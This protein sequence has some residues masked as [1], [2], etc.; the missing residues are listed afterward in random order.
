L[1]SVQS[2]FA[3]QAALAA[4]VS[5]WNKRLGPAL[6]RLAGCTLQKIS[7]TDDG[8]LV[9]GVYRPG[10]DR[11][12]VL[13]SIRRGES[14]LSL[15]NVKPPAQNKPGSLVQMARKHL[16]GRSIA[17]AYAS[18]DPVAVVLEFHPPRAQ[19]EQ[20][21]EEEHGSARRKAKIEADYADCLILDLEARP[22][23]VCV[24]RRLEAVPDRYESVALAFEARHP[25][26]ESLCEWTLET[27]KTKRRP[28]FE[29]PLLPY[30]ILPS[31]WAAEATPAVASP[32]TEGG[33]AV[34]AESTAPAGTQAALES[35]PAAVVLRAPPAPPSQEDSLQ[36]AMTRLP[37]HVRR[38]AKTRLQFLER[39]LL[40]QRQDMPLSAELDALERRAEGMRANLYMWPKDSP[41]WYVPRELIESHGLP[42]VLTLKASE[43]PGDVL[44]RAFQEVDKLKRRQVELTS[45]VAESAKAREDFVTLVLRAAQEV[46]AVREEQGALDPL[47]APSVRASR[48]ARV[49]LKLPQSAGRLLAQLGLEWTEGSQRTREIGEERARRLP[50]RS[51]EASTGEFIRVAKSSA[52]GDAM[53]RLMPSHHTWVH[54]MTGEGSHVWL[55]KPKKL[56]PSS[57]AVREAS[58]LAIHHSRQSRAQEAE[59]YVATRGDIDK[60]KDLAP[61][62]VIVRKAGSLLVRFEDAELQRVLATHKQSTP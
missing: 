56:K 49:A 54:V 32:Q 24:A 41:T 5:I 3:P 14:G 34:T 17:A 46:Q 36:V 7:A 18:L 45:R 22:A 50:Y 44:T 31:A 16:Q 27:T 10:D 55:E 21:Q 4:R 8:T 59:V 61:G 57:Q 39:R 1:N 9:L 2:F 19:G 43:R 15:T 58:I 35:A 48:E 26:F 11:T 6:A 30:C 47:L 20:E 37:T 28:T 38:S 51:Y 25:F 33:A 42:A 53:L 13:L 52:D 40:R 60:R 23:R 62:K 29:V 12:A